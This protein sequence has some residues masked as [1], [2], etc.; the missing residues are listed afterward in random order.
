M[1]DDREEWIKSLK[2]G[3][4]VCDCGYRHSKIIN[5]GE[6]GSG[7]KTLD[8]ENGFSCSARHCCDPVDHQEHWWVYL[9]KCKDKT[10]YT[11][12]AKDCVK[13]I[14]QHNKGKGAKYTRSRTPVK[15]IKRF[16]CH[17]KSEA[18][19]LEYKIKQLSREEKLVFTL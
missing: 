17:S 8:L 18:L 1:T 6:R 13:R 14:E 16:V 15:L 2:V 5:I 10:L 19:K 4:M 7:D 12:I 11:G 9:V 3:D